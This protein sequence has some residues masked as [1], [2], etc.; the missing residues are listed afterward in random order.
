MHCFPNIPARQIKNVCEVGTI[1]TNRQRLRLERKT[2]LGLKPGR[3]EAERRIEASC[4]YAVETTA[5]KLCALTRFRIISPSWMMRSID[6]TA[7]P[8]K[9]QG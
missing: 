9:W 4:A 5:V 2:L 3:F 8:N 6:E 1:A 7:E